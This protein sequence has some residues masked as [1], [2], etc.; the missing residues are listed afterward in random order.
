ME[1][2]GIKI[3][4]VSVQNEPEATQIWES[5]RYTAEE[6]RDFVKDYLGNTLEKEGLGNKKIV[7]WD[8]NRDVAYERAYA[9][10]QILKL[11]NISGV[12]NYT[13]MYLRNFE[14]LSK[15]HNEFPDKHLLFTEGCIEGEL[16]QN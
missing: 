5:C 14:N 7:I 9:I 16:N 10:Y 13:S 8:H 11:Q 1:S 6:E 12:L 2:Q 3:W 4:G 15:I